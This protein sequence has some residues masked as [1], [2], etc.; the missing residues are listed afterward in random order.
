MNILFIS[1]LEVKE[2]GAQSI[3]MTIEGYASKGHKVTLLTHD[4]GDT[5]DY[6]YEEEYVP[7]DKN[8]EIIKFK[9]PLGK[10][11]SK[12]TA[13]NGIRNVI[14]FIIIAFFKGLPL[15]AKKKA[16]IIY[17]YE[18]QGIIAARFIALILRKKMISRFQGTILFPLIHNIKRNKKRW[19]YYSY[20][21][22][23]MRMKS[24]LYIMTN[25]GTRG[26]EVLKY[27]KAP[28]K[29]TRFWMN[30][31][32]KALYNPKYRN[33]LKKKYGLPADAV[34][35]TT[36]HRLVLWKRTERALYALKEVRKTCDNVYL[37]VIGDGDRKEELKKIAKELKID[38]Y[39]FFAGGVPNEKIVR[40]INGADIYLGTFDLSNAGN[41]LF[42][43]MLAGLAVISLNNGT[44]ADFL[45]NGKAGTL[46]EK[47]EEFPERII[48]LVQDKKSLEKWKESAK[49]Y[50]H[51]KFWT[52]D[53][54]IAKEVTEVE[55]L[56]S[57]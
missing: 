10:I 18:V 3:R 40:Y 53:E 35:L 44:T 57:S 47:E 7:K 11:A 9:L 28:E 42:E 43:A 56:L 51:Q 46:I 26:D 12:S 1:A 30:G 22:V 13:L 14:L 6:V 4:K 45:G 2:K 16:D 20:H 19:V 17:G 49:N 50:S 21:R 32:N 39:T 31:V 24:D 23:A 34:I 8:I 52:W 25:D 29:K 55:N 27:F 48:E 15:A 41:P 54:R 33:F 36:V 5:G 38:K 37:V